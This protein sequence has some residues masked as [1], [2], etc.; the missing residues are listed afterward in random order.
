MYALR[1]DGH[2]K[3]ARKHGKTGVVLEIVSLYVSEFRLI[4]S[5]VTHLGRKIPEN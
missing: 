1:T 3:D 2:I 4:G 5:N